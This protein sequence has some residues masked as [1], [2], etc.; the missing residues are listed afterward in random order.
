M[1]LKFLTFYYNTSTTIGLRSSS[2]YYLLER[3]VSAAGT[4]VDFFECQFPLLE[5]ET[6]SVIVDKTFCLD[7]NRNFSK[8]LR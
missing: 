4:Y 1:A 8:T 6:S 3:L 5:N 7:N 2:T